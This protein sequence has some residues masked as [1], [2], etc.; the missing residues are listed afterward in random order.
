MEKKCKEIQTSTQS[1]LVPPSYFKVIWYYQPKWHLN[2]PP[3]TPLTP[4][5]DQHVTSPYNIPI[6]FSKQVMRILKLIRY[7]ISYCLDWTR[8]SHNQFTGKCVAARGENCE[9]ECFLLVTKTFY[10]EWF[11]LSGN[12]WLCSLIVWVRKILKG[13]LSLV[14]DHVLTT[15]AR[16]L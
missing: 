13:M 12:T 9:S 7:K 3:L 1:K 14:L 15:W 16:S 10:S 8:N 4:R 11:E 2:W 6:L 5:I